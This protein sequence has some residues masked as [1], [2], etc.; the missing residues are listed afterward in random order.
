MADYFP[1]G[2]IV[3]AVGNPTTVGGTAMTVLSETEEANADAGIQNSFATTAITAGAPTSSAVYSLPPQVSLAVRSNDSDIDQLVELMLGGERLTSSTLEA[4]GF[5]GSIEKL[6]LPTWCFIPVFE[7]ADG[8][9]AKH[10]I[11]IP[12]GFSEGLNNIL[13]NR[14][15]GNASSNN[16]YNYTVRSA[17]RKTDQLS[18]NI[19]AKFQY[20]WMGPPA[21]VGL[22]WYLPAITV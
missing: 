11:W 19:P 5:G 9:N 10:A 18:A 17:R 4:V 16:A 8:V 6:A 20:G 1:I 13:H 15:Q 22:T 7:I 21:A 2:P 3:V 12:A 14:M